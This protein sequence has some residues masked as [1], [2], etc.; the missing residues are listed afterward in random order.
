MPTEFVF[1]IECDGFNPTK[2]HCLSAKSEKGLRSTVSYDKM[3]DFFLDPDKI[4]ICH[5]AKRFDVPVV[6]RLLDIKVKCRVV[7]TLALSWYLFP[8][9]ILHGLESWGVDFGVPKPVVTDWDGLTPEEY[10]HRCEEDVKINFKLWQKCWAY[11]LR[12][13]GTE[14]KA[15]KLIDYL[16]FKFDCARDQEDLRWKL[17]IPKCQEAFERLSL[18]KD[19]KVVELAKAMPSI[20]II[21][22]RTKPPKPF[23][24]DGSMS[25]AGIKWKAL[26]E[27]QGLPEDYDGEVSEV[28]G[29]KAPNPNSPHQI[30]GWLV[31]LDWIPQTF[32][33]KRDKETNEVKMIPQV[34]LEHG[35]GICPSIKRLYDKEP[36]LEVLDGLAVLTHR[37]SILKGFLAAVDE[38]G[39]VQAKI[40]GLTN[41][42]RF[43]HKVVVNLPSVDKPY[44]SDIRGCLTAPSG[45]ELIGSDM[46]SLEDRTK[47]H[48]MWDHDPAYVTEMNTEGFDPHLDIGVLAGMMTQQQSDEFKGGDKS[49][50]HIRHGAKQVNYSCTYGITPAGLER[51]TGMPIDQCTK[52]HTTYWKRNWS[53]QAIA[54]ACKVKTVNGQKW[55]YN[56]VSELWYSLR[57]DKDRFSTLNQGTGTYCFDMWV[58]EIKKSGLPVIGQMHDEYIGLIKLGLRDRATKVTKAAVKAVNIQLKLNRELDCDVAFGNNYSE[59]H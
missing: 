29:A 52:L 26:L 53:V 41:T 2:I 54:D 16:M 5:N 58:K 23:K 6:E 40:Q 19:V 30:K 56:S 9:R 1:D 21:A 55:L 38:E 32:K 7:D 35:K 43:K 25:V 48:Y 24:K 12:L 14:E 18:L 57:H 42:L 11:L 37:I 59:I 10:I 28:T 17:D 33:Y 44:G 51:N 39:Y 34:N 49:L 13:Y 15:W 45:Y 27:A 20:D 36:A 31:G 22:V 46:S 4:I 8:N 50:N 47:Q 3:R